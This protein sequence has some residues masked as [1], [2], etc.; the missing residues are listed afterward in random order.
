MVK[1]RAYFRFYGELND[2]LPFSLRQATIERTF[3]DQ[4]SVK[5]M[6]EAIGVPHVEVDLLVANRRSVDF[7]YH[8]NDGD[9]ISVYP[10]FRSI[11][12]GL[13]SKVRP[14]PLDPIRFVLD[15][16]LGKLAGYCACWASIRTIKIR[17]KMKRWLV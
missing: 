12:V 11:D 7:D 5:D 9:T 1:K 3:I 10:C 4:P 15:C 17:L 2:F 14:C 6:I 16:H 13:E 8:V